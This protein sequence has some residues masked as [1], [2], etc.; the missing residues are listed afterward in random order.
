[1]AYIGPLPAE[2]FTSFATQEFSTSATT[3]Y[4]LDHPVTNE[5][6]LAL[7]INNVRQQPGSGKA[8]TAVGTALTLSAATASTDTMYAVFLGR[9]LQTVNPADS[10]V[11]ASQVA[12]NLISGKT[13]LA[14]TPADTDELLISDAGTLKRIDYSYLKGNLV[15]LSSATASNSANITFDS[16]VIT[17]TYKYYQIHCIDVLCATDGTALKF[18]ISVDNGSNYLNSGGSLL[19]QANDTGDSNDAISTRNNTSQTGSTIF[20]SVGGFGNDTNEVGQ[21]II[22]LF[23]PSGSRAKLFIVHANYINNNGELQQQDGHHAWINGTAYNN[24]KIVADSG[25]IT[26]GSFILY[27]VAS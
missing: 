15:K 22:H 26:S 6:E 7:F 21:A 17:S 9:A 14:A 27:G 23:N 18:N 3:S 12:D 16:S 11:G 13:A 8:Y 1:M 19:L 20:G 25:N 5:N 10:S 4:T 24:I 2:T